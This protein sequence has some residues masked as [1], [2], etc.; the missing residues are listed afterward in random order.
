MSVS[1]RRGTRSN[2][3]KPHGPRAASADPRLWH[4]G[5]LVHSCDSVMPLN[6][7]VG[8]LWPAGQIWPKERF[9]ALL[10]GWGKKSKEYFVMWKLYEIVLLGRSH[11]HS[12]S[13]CPQFLSDYKGRATLLWQGSQ[14]PQNLQYFRRGLLGKNICWL[15]GWKACH[16]FNEVLVVY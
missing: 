14:D 2:Q 15:L 8:S 4:Q 3:G 6:E 5:D 12:F 13:Y 1:N 7:S 9:C 16:G 11:A 10:I